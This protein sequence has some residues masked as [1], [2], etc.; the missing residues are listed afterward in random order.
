MPFGRYSC[1]AHYSE[2]KCVSIMNE[3]GG[4]TTPSCVAFDPCGAT[5][6]LGNDAKQQAAVKYAPFHHWAELPPVA[7]L[8]RLVPQPAQYSVRREAAAW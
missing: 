7:K 3:H 8:T 1:A 5:R 2:G 6:L 4:T